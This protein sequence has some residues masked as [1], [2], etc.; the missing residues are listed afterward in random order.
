LLYWVFKYVAFAPLCRLLFRPSVS[1][2]ENIP[3]SGGGILA[4]NHISAG[5]TFLLPAMI[6]RRVTFPAKKELFQGRG[7]SG[8]I[9]TWF[10]KS[11]GQLPMDRSGGRASGTSME[12][13][14]GV[15]RSGELLGIYP[16]GTR[17][18][19]GRLYRGKTGVARLVLQARVPLIPVGMINTELVPS[20]FFKI[21]TMHRPKIRIGEPMDF[22]AYADAGNDRDVLR[23]VTDEIMNAIMELSGQ[24]Y[25]DVYGGAAKAALEAEKPLPPSAGHRP[26]AGRPRPPIPAPKARLDLPPVSDVNA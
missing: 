15:L 23:W 2:A 21:P 25:V 24:A 26:G 4:S 20:R 14:F 6:R 17:S 16:E 10:L 5:D 18:P 13:V 1:G 9:L 19:D 22:T 7:V 3:K 11:V 8:R 12:G